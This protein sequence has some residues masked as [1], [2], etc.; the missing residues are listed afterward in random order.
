MVDIYIYIYISRERERERESKKERVGNR[1]PIIAEVVPP[2]APTVD[3][4]GPLL[5]A[6]ETKMTPCLLT[7]SDN[8]SHTRLKYHKINTR[9]NTNTLILHLETVT[10]QSKEDCNLDSL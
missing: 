7:A 5:P 8:I 1:V 2:G 10:T 9:Y 6:D 3:K 4:A